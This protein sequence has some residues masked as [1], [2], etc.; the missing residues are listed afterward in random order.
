MDLFIET[1]YGNSKKEKKVR[2]EKAGLNKEADASV[3]TAKRHKSISCRPSEIYCKTFV[4]WKLSTPTRHAIQGDVPSL[5]HKWYNS[6]NKS[7][8]E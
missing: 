5:L 7:S 2:K 8:V 3:M 1:Y 6:Q 4:G